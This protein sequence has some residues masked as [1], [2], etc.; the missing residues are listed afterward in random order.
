VVSAD[1][2]PPANAETERSASAQDVL[3]RPV[4]TAGGN[5]SFGELTVADVEARAGELRAATGW[6]PTARIASVAR[7][8]AELAKAMTQA[9]A[10]TVAELDPQDASARA[11]A[12]WIVPPGGS[13]L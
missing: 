10:A 7:A 3:G 12:L 5:K 2:E 4:Y 13:L 11:R 1:A 6:G 9:G 8:W